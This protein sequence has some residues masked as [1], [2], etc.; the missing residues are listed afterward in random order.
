VTVT[1]FVELPV[2]EIS[3]VTNAVIAAC[4]FAIV[5]V[6]L[7]GLLRTGQMRSNALGL[8]TAMIFFTCAVHHGS[9]AVHL[10][11]PL[12]TDDAHGLAMRQA[13][14]WQM[15]AW[16]VFGAVVGIVYLSL[17]SS[18]GRLLQTPSIFRD[19]SQA[20]V[21]AAIAAEHEALNEAQA[22]GQMGSWRHEAGSGEWEVSAEFRR[23]LELAVD[24][25]PGTRQRA[26]HPDDFAQVRAAVG[27]ARDGQGSETS[28]RLV[29]RDG[30]EALLHLRARP[31]LDADGQVVAVAG[32]VQDR[33]Q[34]AAMEAAVHEAEQRFRTAF[35]AAPIGVC[36]VSL[37]SVARGHIV[38]ANPALGRL[39]GHPVQQLISSSLAALVHPEDHHV[40]DQS[41]AELAGDERDGVELEA[42]LMHRD[43]HCVWAFISAAALPARGSEPRLVV[44]NVMDVS[45]RK[46]FEGQLQYL[47]DHDALTG[48]FNRRRFTEELDRALKHSQRYG[49]PGAV[50]FLDLDGF[51]FVNDSLGHAAGDDLIARVGAM[52]SS[53]I[54]GTD[55]L[56]RVGG[57]EFAVIL[58]RSS[59]KDAVHVAEKLLAVI[60][61]EGVVVNEHR[62]AHVSTSIG[63]TLF[64]EDDDL[65]ADELLVEADIAMYDAKEA[66]KDRYSL[67]VRAEGHRSQIS[68]RE[69]WNH[70]LSA[71]V[72]TGRF[73]LHAQPIVPLASMT[74]PTFELLLRLPDDHGDL[75]PPGTFLYN[76][77]RFGLMTRIDQWVLRQAVGLL[78][79]SHAAGVDLALTV[80]VSGKTITDP[81]LG[82]YVAR[83][84]AERKVTRDRLT[85][86]ITETAAITNVEHARA[87]SRELRALGC[88]IALDDFGAGFATFYYLK[89]LEFDD[90]KIDGEF[91]RNLCTTPSDRLVVR[92]VVDIARG[93]NART[94]AEF[95]GDDDT[96][97]LL[98]TLG[99]DG[100]Q[101]YHLGRPQ[102]LEAVLP[103]L[104]RRQERTDA[105]AA[106]P[107]AATT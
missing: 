58:T 90:V 3:A 48:L 40:I 79:D 20:R 49:D 93:L 69:D 27:D 19:M 92:A 68:V 18:F 91:I 5:W 10:M 64:G 50:L 30:T 14:T 46:K 96:V 67:Y 15:A 102:A 35:E 71:A 83:L 87:L 82:A 28:F 73:V 26:I 97:R 16:D 74:P 55:V 77:E 94:I 41:L 32:T 88:R 101:G 107:P 1:A 98:T 4:Y 6:I 53:T 76:A 84:L 43:G 8:V 31:E 59:H 95:V 86:E 78:A 34:Q 47:A 42:R 45:Q 7:G 23:I 89:H 51:K 75:I 13:F 100:G 54:R 56:A 72:D 33:T 38:S 106:A 105:T 11:L 81:S 61:R 99:V 70:R 85:I 66:G 65:T 25:D 103:H 39:L 44:T 21:D 62:H 12:V 37:D 36:V 2:W 9:H 29:R 60:R 63:I 17:R 57:D 22:I 24:E 80:N 52:F 104:R